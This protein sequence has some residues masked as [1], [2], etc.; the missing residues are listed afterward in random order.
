[1]NKLSKEALELLTTAELYEIKAGADP[2]TSPGPDK[3]G[4]CLF[5]S[6]CVGCSTECMACTTEYLDVIVVP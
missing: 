1:M 6:T 4:D 5:C 3:P 2:G